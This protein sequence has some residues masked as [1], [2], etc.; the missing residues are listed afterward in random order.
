MSSSHPFV[1]RRVAAGVIVVGLLGSCADSDSQT[2]IT[3]GSDDAPTSTATEGMTA[4]R[5]S[6]LCARTGVSE[7]GD[8]ENDALTEASGLVASRT[9]PE[10]V[11]SH[12][13]GSDGRLFA[14]GADGRDLGV[15]E[16]V[17]EG[18]DDIEDIALIS[19]PDGSEALLADIGDNDVDRSAIRIYRFPEPDPRSAGPIE[20]I[21][22]LEYV[23]PDRPHNAETLLVDQASD[24]LVIVT[25]AQL[26]DDGVQGDLGSTAASYVFEGPLGGASEAP[27][28]LRAVGIIDMVALEERAEKSPRHPTRLI[29][30]AGVPTGGDVSADGS[31]IALRTYE[32]VWVWPRLEQQSVAE[33]L[34]GEPCEVGAAFEV[35]GEAVAF[36]SEGLATLGEGVNR[37]LHLIGSSQ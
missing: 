15:H 25:K 37:P 34:L 9:Y 33:A 22:V 5:A 16:L 27:I 19:G 21:E 4:D 18:V 30:A 29:G 2:S 13:D 26:T 20:E 10:V 28:E 17:V 1:C 8:V 11:W 12:N 14:I 6:E 7:A 36:T 35:Q 24:V 3:L 32:T 23:Y 31:L